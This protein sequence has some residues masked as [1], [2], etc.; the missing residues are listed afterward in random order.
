MIKLYD[1]N[2]TYITDIDNHVRVGYEKDFRATWSATLELLAN[3]PVNIM[4]QPFFMIDIWDDYG[5]YIGMYRILPKSASVSGNSSI[6]SYNCHHVLHTLLDSTIRKKRY[7]ENT[8]LPT[9]IKDVLKWQ[10]EKHWVT[11]NVSSLTKVQGMEM[12]VQTGLLSP[13]LELIGHSSVGE[14]YTYNTL[15]YPWVLNV[16]KV[17]PLNC[18]IKEGY[19]MSSFEIETDPTGIVNRVYGY[20]AIPEESTE[21][22]PL[23]P[24]TVA[25][26]NNGLEYV[27]DADSISKYGVK[28][29]VFTDERYESD[30][31]L[32][33]TMKY[34][35]KTLSSEVVRVRCTAHD[36]IKA[37]DKPLSIDEIR[38]GRTVL[39][40]TE[41]FGTFEMTITKEGK[42]DIFGDPT[43]ME[44]ELSLDYSSM[45]V[46]GI[47]RDIQIIKKE[48]IATQNAV[49]IAADGKTVVET[50][51][52]E[53]VNPKV[54][55]L[56]YKQVTDLET[57]LIAYKMHVWNGETWRVIDDDIDRAL[58]DLAASK[59]LI[60]S[61]KTQAD[62]LAIDLENGLSMALTEDG[63]LDA[64]NAKANRI[65]FVA[66]GDG[67]HHVLQLTSDGVFIDKGLIQ[68]AHIA[69]GSITDAKI[70]DLTFG[71]A[72]GQTIDAQLIRVVN[73]DANS[74]TSGKFS[75]ERLEIGSITREHIAD[76][77]LDEYTTIQQWNEFLVS[78]DTFK[79]EITQTVT[80]QM[81]NLE[82]TL[83]SK[84]QQQ[85]DS[86]RLSV[87]TEVESYVEDNLD[88]FKGADGANFT[89]NMLE[90]G[91]L[92][93]SKI[94]YS[95]P[96][97]IFLVNRSDAKTEKI[98]NTILKFYSHALSTTQRLERKFTSLD[99]GKYTYSVR[100]RFLNTSLKSGAWNLGEY[101]VHERKAEQLKVGEWQTLS[102]PFEVKIKD[103]NLNVLRFYLPSLE[104]GASVEFD[105]EKLEKGT[106]LNPTWSPH[107]SEIYGIDG[108]NF[109]WNL[110]KGSNELTYTGTASDTYIPRTYIENGITHYEITKQN[111]TANTYTG[112]RADINYSDL[113]KVF[114]I[115]FEVMLNDISEVIANMYLGTIGG[116]AGGRRTTYVDLTTRQVGVELKE[117]IWQKVVINVDENLF[118]S[119]TADYDINKITDIYITLGQ[120]HN[121]KVTFRKL[122]FNGGTVASNYA[123]HITE[124]QGADG[125][126]G[127]DGIGITLTTIEYAV[128]QSGTTHPTTGWSG[129]VPKTNPGDYIWTK[130]TWNY[131]DNTSEDAY[132]VGRIGVDGPDGEDGLPGA[133]GVGIK[134]TTITYTKSNSGTVI[135][136]ST[137]TWSPTPPAGNPGEF[138]WTRTV[139]T[140]TDNTTEAGYSVGK[141]GNTGPQGPQGVQG[142]NGKDG[143]P[144]V[145]GKPGIGISKTVI[146]Y[147][148]STS[149]ITAPTTGYTTTVPT[150]APGNFLWTRTTWIY[151]DATT[152]TSYSVGLIGKNGNTGADGNPG[153]DGVGIDKTLIEYAKNTSGTVKPTTGWSTTIPSTVPGD[154]LWTRTTW[155]YTDTTI[156]QGYT[157]GKIGNTGPQGADGAD[158]QQPFYRYSNDKINMSLTDNNHLYIGLYFGYYASNNP[159]DY[160]WIDKRDLQPI[161]Q[162]TE[163]NKT[164]IELN[165]KEIALKV[166]TATYQGEQNLINQK[167]SSL[168]QKDDEIMAKFDNIG[169]TNL[170]KDS[171]VLTGWQPYDGNTITET[172]NHMV[173]QWDTTSAVRVKTNQGDQTT[174][175]KAFKLMGT[176]DSSMVGKTITFSIYV[177]NNREYPMSVS[178]NCL[179]E[180]A[181][182]PANTTRRVSVTGKIKAG[183]STYVIWLYSY[184]SAYYLDCTVYKAL[185]DV[186]TKLNE[187]TQHPDEHSSGSTK[188]NEEGITVGKF[189]EEVETT[190]KNDG[191][192]VYDTISE[193][194]ILEATRDGG[195]FDVIYANDIISDTIV[196]KINRNF[197][198]YVQGNATGDGSGRDTNNRADSISEALEHT[199][200]GAKYLN[201]GVTI[202]VHVYGAINEIAF[203]AGFIGQ[204]DINIFG[205][206]GA[207]ITGR[208]ILSSC[209]VHVK[210]SDL[211]FVLDP[212]ESALDNACILGHKMSRMIVEGCVFDGPSVG[213]GNGIITTGGTNLS[214]GNSVF[215]DFKYCVTADTLSNVSLYN[216]RGSDVNALGYASGGAR[217]VST[218]Y[219]PVQTYNNALQNND[220]W[221]LGGTGTAT[222]GTRPVISTPT[223]K[224]VSKTFYARSVGTRNNGSSYVWNTSEWRQGTWSG[225]GY[226]VIGFAEFG[227][228]IRDW[229]NGGGGFAGTVT[230]KIEA[231]RTGS[232]YGSVGMMIASPSAT[233][234]P[235]VARFAKTSA[236]LASGIVENM[237]AASSFRIQ[238]NTSSTSNYAGFKDIK[239][240]VT[241]QKKI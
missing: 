240:T 107:E 151:T 184:S 72:V 35:L 178:L 97:H 18:R 24:I 154:F 14:Y 155:M 229:L 230:A 166:S 46:T 49:R 79:S 159:D 104:V 101:V 203:I 15:V 117:N 168:T 197:D 58:E 116:L 20:G 131:T 162:R 81:G 222:A 161:V 96:N 106:N 167:L 51:P 224:T 55:T 64:I 164:A 231:T 142:A 112:Y 200:G 235:A 205:Y 174:N 209:T 88:R 68:E 128:N 5:E 234:T 25:N 84:I 108:S 83:N 74:V 149:G 45:P 232:G 29:Y 236:N 10:V 65:I 218:G 140:Y 227:S 179:D 223:F 133:P 190:I 4:I 182:V 173:S 158:G 33:E 119:K 110:L 196:K 130:I 93:F 103:T 113:P 31:S 191:L 129:T 136:P 47:S 42:S 202:N 118:H 201:E 141:I 143:I 157:V 146:D 36:I 152:E 176:F 32:L 187:W 226:H 210:I 181:T 90:N 75:G 233:N 207:K 100:L 199:L 22:D 237:K 220:A 165:K 127:K 188:I 216:V 3:D 66:G 192:R 23:P 123:P 82:Q 6:I 109:T 60:D 37:S 180:T 61:V 28:E 150:V 62:Q 85:V 12:G 16:A 124:I 175:L 53:P 172:Y 115:S 27:E 48:I 138:I 2:R 186:G 11:G 170:I 126:P 144:G 145:D 92:D 169:G 105:W 114:T 198:I 70:G 148:G 125:A 86:I 120:F 43:T 111:L 241:C 52:N 193:T 211:T 217:M 94:N 34:I 56:W 221:T 38:M 139:W 80:D 76:G 135:P 171:M 69:N 204:G 239:I 7:F 137:A 185:I 67:T 30:T 98:D 77:A 160:T 163:E 147:A 59:V 177:R 195:K 121:G 189:G 41:D 214:L 91:H 183:Y 78:Y 215:Y 39:F 71:W 208:M 63:V 219:R 89:W 212:A 40:D 54:G 57:G 156:E 238:S 13:L 99:T 17:T 95:V 73:L 153:K 228:A 8:D 26:I 206:S 44:I 102:I 9:A 87:S 132:S 19:N 21:D 194:S 1:R 122:M 50:G 134:M 225:D 213:N